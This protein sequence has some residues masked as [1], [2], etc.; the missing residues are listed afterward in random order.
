MPRETGSDYEVARIQRG[1]IAHLKDIAVMLGT[2]G[3]KARNF[4]IETAQESINR[5]ILLQAEKPWISEQRLIQINRGAS[6][7]R[8]M[9]DIAPFIA[10]GFEHTS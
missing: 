8:T 10:V 7:M 1:D 9:P 2:V 3:P 4:Y 5:L 6:A